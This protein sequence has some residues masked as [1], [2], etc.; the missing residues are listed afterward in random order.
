MVMPG[1]KIANKI[2]VAAG[3]VVTKDLDKEGWL[4]GGIPAKP[5]KQL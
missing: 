1:V 3:S 2:I 4:Y 5:F